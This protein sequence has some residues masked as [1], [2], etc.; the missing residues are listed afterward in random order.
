MMAT[1]GSKATT[2]SKLSAKIWSNFS[3]S[4]HA[5][6]FLTSHFDVLAALISKTDL[7]TET[8][9]RAGTTFRGINF[10]GFDMIAENFD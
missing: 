4:L 10:D 5:V 7:F 2:I 9:E 1:V 3:S 6:G 8:L